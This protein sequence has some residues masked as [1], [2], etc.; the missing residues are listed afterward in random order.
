M[1]ELSALTRRAKDRNLPP[2][3]A[4]RRLQPIFIFSIFSIEFYAS[5]I[6]AAVAQLEEQRSCL[7]LLLQILERR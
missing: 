2:Q 5:C 1:V 4:S 7:N 6:F 3:P